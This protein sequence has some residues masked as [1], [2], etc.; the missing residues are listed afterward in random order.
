VSKEGKKEK[1]KTEEA[2][3]GEPAP[4]RAKEKKAKAV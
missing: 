3:E 2:A 4:K 1:R